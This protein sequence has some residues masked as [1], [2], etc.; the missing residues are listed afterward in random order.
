MSVEGGPQIRGGMTI[1][2]GSIRGRRIYGVWAAV[3]VIAL[4][5]LSAVAW[6]LLPESSV[7]G[8]QA[9]TA[10][11][12]PNWEF[13]YGGT[14]QYTPG[15]AMMSST[16]EFANGSSQRLRFISITPN[17]TSACPIK[18]LQQSAYS[19]DGPT[20]YAIAADETPKELGYVSGIPISRVS[21][22]PHWVTGR[23]DTFT[24]LVPGNSKSVSPATPRVTS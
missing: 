24:F 18:M 22:R 19:N 9:G 11:S 14:E 3:C 16:P 21:L 1:K 13:R 12:D 8:P 15:S 23:F 2:E 4:V 10:L 7:K 17:Y 6:V 20:V 5:P